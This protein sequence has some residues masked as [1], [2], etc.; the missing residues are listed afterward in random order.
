[1]TPELNSHN[2]LVPVSTTYLSTTPSIPVTGTVSRRD[3]H[4]SS[5]FGTLNLSPRGEQMLRDSITKNLDLMGLGSGSESAC[6]S[7]ATTLPKHT[8]S[9]PSTQS[10]AQTTQPARPGSAP[11]SLPTRTGRRTVSG[12]NTNTSSLFLG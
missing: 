5:S 8:F 3:P 6:P 11:A 12:L 1:M 10:S 7:T 4:Q 2:S 9:A